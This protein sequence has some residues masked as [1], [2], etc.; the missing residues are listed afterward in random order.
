M[1]V[2]PS[3]PPIIPMEAAS[4]MLNPNRILPIKVANIPNWAAAPN[5]IRRGLAIKVEK[6]VI[7]PIPKKIREG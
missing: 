6:S 5:K 3:A 1:E 7:A 4:K 2:G